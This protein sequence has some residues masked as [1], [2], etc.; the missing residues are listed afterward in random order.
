MTKVRQIG[1]NMAFIW[2]KNLC[3]LFT[4]LAILAVLMVANGTVA[5]VTGTSFLASAPVLAI[6]LGIRLRVRDLPVRRDHVVPV[7]A[8]EVHGQAGRPQIGMGFQNY[9]GQPDLLEHAQR[10]SAI[11]RGVKEFE[12]RGGEMP[13]GLLLSGGPGTGKTFL[14]AAS[15]RKRSCR[16]S[17]STR[18]RCGARSSASPS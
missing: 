17:T 5:V 8:A 14:A 9:R 4:V 10:R 13:K 11:L 12:L 6:Q 7:A 18:A 2:N 3:R 15:R 1:S 16:S